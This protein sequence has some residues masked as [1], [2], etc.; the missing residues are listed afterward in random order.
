MHACIFVRDGDG[1]SALQHSK[2]YCRRACRAYILQILQITDLW[3][4]I[5]LDKSKQKQT[6]HL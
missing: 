4:K 2:C 3:L 5:Q 6:S 1:V